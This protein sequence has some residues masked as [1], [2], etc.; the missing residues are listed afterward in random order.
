MNK[1]RNPSRFPSFTQK[2]YHTPSNLQSSSLLDI[3][4][5]H[6]LDSIESLQEFHTSTVR[7]LIHLLTSE[8]KKHGSQTPYIF[9]PF[10]SQNDDKK[11]SFF[12]KNVLQN[13]NNKPL[14]KSVIS[15][16]DVFTLISSL[17][18]LWS[19]L[20]NQSIIEWDAYLK[21]KEQERMQGYPRTA[22]LDIMPSCLST[23]DSASIVYDFLDLL[24]RIAA[25]TKENKLSG[26]KVARL[27]GL[28]VFNGPPPNDSNLINDYNRNQPSFSNGLKVWS[29]AADATFHLLLSFI[30]G[31]AQND[32][33]KNKT[34]EKSLLSL[35]ERNSYPPK[36]SSSSSHL[37]SIPIVTIYSQVLSSDPLELIESASKT[38]SFDRP[39]LYDDA[40][41]YKIL[42]S[43]F[44]DPKLDIQDKL[45]NESSKILV[46]LSKDNEYPLL[47]NGWYPQFAPLNSSILSSDDEDEDI[48]PNLPLHKA[49][50][51]K[52][53]ID[54]YY[55]WAWMASLSPE[56]SDS[57]RA[58]FGNTIIAEFTYAKNQV[59]WLAIQECKLSD[60]KND[61]IPNSLKTR[62]VIVDD[63]DKPL[64]NPSKGGDV[65]RSSSH[66]T[67]NTIDSV[68]SSKSARSFSGAKFK[69]MFKFGKKN[70]IEKD[71]N[72]DFRLSRFIVA[73]NIGLLPEIET[74]DYR[75]SMPLGAFTFD[76]IPKTAENSQSKHE[77]T[78]SANNK[79]TNSM[80][81]E[82]SNQSTL[83]ITEK[84]AV[85]GNES[86]TKSMID[87]YYAPSD[88]MISPPVSPGRIKSQ[89]YDDI[90]SKNSRNS[91]REIVNLIDNLNFQ[92]DE[93]EKQLK[94]SSSN[95]NSIKSKRSTLNTF[96]DD[97]GLNEPINTARTSVSSLKN[98]SLVGATA[99]PNPY[100]DEKIET[101]PEPTVSPVDPNFDKKFIQTLDTNNVPN[102]YPQNSSPKR[103]SRQ[104]ARNSS[105]LRNNINF[106]EQDDSIDDDDDSHNNLSI[107]D[108]YRSTVSVNSNKRI[109]NNSNQPPSHNSMNSNQLQNINSIPSNKYPGSINSN[110]HS[111]ARQSNLSIN[112][113]QSKTSSFQQV[114]P[115]AYAAQ[116]EPQPNIQ[117]INERGE[118]ENGNRMG[119]VNNSFDS[120]GSVH[121]IDGST[122][123][124]SPYGQYDQAGYNQYNGNVGKNVN[125]GPNRSSSPSKRPANYNQDVPQNANIEE[126]KPPIRGPPPVPTANPPAPPVGMNNYSPQQ[127]HQE[128][129]YGDVND[130]YGDNYNQIPQQMNAPPQGAQY[131][132]N[133][134][135]NSSN[136]SLPNSQRNSR[137]RGFAPNQG[138]VQGPIPGPIPNQNVQTPQQA[139]QQDYF[140]DNYYDNG[141]YDNNGNYYNNDNYYQQQAPMQQPVQPQSMPPMGSP[142]QQGGLPPPSGPPPPPPPQHQYNGQYNNQYRG[143]NLPQTVNYNNQA[144]NYNN[145]AVSPGQSQPYRGAIR[146]PVARNANDS[147]NSLNNNT[148]Y[149]QRYYQQPIPPAQQQGQGQAMGMGQ[150]MPAPINTQMYGPPSQPQSQNQSPISPSGR[151][152][153]PNSRPQPR[154]RGSGGYGGS[155]KMNGNTSP[156]NPPKTTSDL[157]IS[158]MPIVSGFNKL[159]GPGSKQTDKKNLRAAL[160]SNNML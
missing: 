137:T 159:H 148:N 91:L 78:L 39:E 38:L 102:F 44:R 43:L 80:V 2:Q 7:E 83:T 116:K 156:T 47:K 121:N 42:R 150:P 34:T 52:I 54:D 73:E 158:G 63:F 133:N 9:L 106:T 67:T 4:S 115:L 51:S 12:L 155:P 6:D 58:L 46:K 140:E 139:P 22:F 160:M 17:K 145:Q 23:P 82:S 28:W 136:R 126:R 75:L 26:R 104:L 55:I 130:G 40:N 129:Y 61:T 32:K 27:A 15:K 70:K 109:S 11:L 119:D 79:N 97:K 101:Y 122:P 85:S 37:T 5:I 74:N 154:F 88:L 149:D 117:P 1:V 112:S 49:T 96:N 134:T 30:R 59:K 144:V 108:K 18:Y 124:T 103:N 153:T 107:I 77:S 60:P 64:L 10:R 24:V 141:Y 33:Q 98:P 110:R 72:D 35:I 66:Y 152:Q 92:T 142:I 151:F 114:A 157:A 41:H 81:P 87:N 68:S 147:S 120:T 99:I 53:L 48:N 25:Y 113:V 56:S 71:K 111:N 14:I 45:T 123:G 16:T 13:I 69:N 86:P 31:M 128:Q 21:F 100:S 57:K 3:D 62:N 65:T 131:Y 94:S 135:N 19:R 76:D 125:N 29:P 138:Q 50:V 146:Y 132:N 89:F 127:P 20:P 36:N 95:I 118:Y 105:P 84:L 8:I 143:P 90:S 93:V